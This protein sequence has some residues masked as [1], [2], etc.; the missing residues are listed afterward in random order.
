M[1]EKKQTTDIFSFVRKR[2]GSV[3]TEKVRGE[4][5]LKLNVSPTAK[6]RK[7]GFTVSDL[8][9]KKQKELA[10]IRAKN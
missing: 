5:L 10:R 8:S 3:E 2:F 7:A 1:A 6:Q 9:P 4:E